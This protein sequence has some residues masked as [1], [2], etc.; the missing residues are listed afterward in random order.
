[1]GRTEHFEAGQGK[2]VWQAPVLRA[3][4]EES[5]SPKARGELLGRVGGNFH[6]DGGFPERWYPTAEQNP[7]YLEW[8]DLTASLAPGWRR[9][10]TAAPK[11][12]AP[13]LK[14]E[15]DLNRGKY[16]GPRRFRVMLGMALRAQNRALGGKT[17]QQH[18]IDTIVRRSKMSVGGYTPE[19][20]DMGGERF[21]PLN[22]EKG[23]PHI[24]AMADENQGHAQV[25]FHGTPTTSMVK[26]PD[27]P[28]V[29]DMSAEDYHYPGRMINLS[30]YQFVNSEAA[31]RSNG[32]Q[33]SESGNLHRNANAKAEEE[34]EGTG[35]SPSLAPPGVYTSPDPFFSGRYGTRV[36]S[37]TTSLTV[38]LAKNHTQPHPEPP[39][40]RGKRTGR[41]LAFMPLGHPLISGAQFGYPEEDV[42]A[43]ILMGKPVHVQNVHRTTADRTQRGYNAEAKGSPIM[44]PEAAPRPITEPGEKERRRAALGTKVSGFQEFEAK[45]RE[46]KEPPKSREEKIDDDWV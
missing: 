29:G 1:M 14:P 6:P 21:S 8:S 39:R 40:P 42:R 11:W 28:E 32:L 7:P 9:P 22:R 5:V 15:R 33:P 26:N 4:P 23:Y 13:T 31:I 20:M 17:P 27:L 18:A 44:D 38:K 3:M 10:D 24:E 34:A 30:Q 12:E 19:Q 41:L 25:V 37:P 46:S 45:A 16:D 35:E 2:Q 36:M 43:P